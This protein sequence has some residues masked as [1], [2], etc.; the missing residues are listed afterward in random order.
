MDQSLIK[1]LE[2]SGFTDKEARVYLALLELGK[3]NVTEIAK[4]SSLKRPIIYIILEGLIKRGFASELPEQKINTYQA[5]DPS[6][7]LGQLRGIT[8]NFSEMLPILRTLGGKGKK[9][10]KIRYY[11]TKEGILKIWD[12][13]MN[14]AKEAFFISSYKR[15]EE[16]FPGKIADWTEKAGKGLVNKG[17]RHLISNSAF[18]L[19]LAK[20]FLAIEQKVRIMPELEISHMDFTIYDNKLAITSLEDEPFIVVIES[21]ELVNSIRPLFEM[22]WNNGREIK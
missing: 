21:E 3:G 8:R 2:E 5:T 22:A 19:E 17:F 6:V 16:R 20:K 7:I 13:E 15:I 18:E 1:L 12:G 14:V 4:I 9:R 10:P 11:D